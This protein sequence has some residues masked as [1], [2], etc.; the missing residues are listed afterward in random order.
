VTFT[1][2]FCVIKDRISRNLIGVGKVK[3]EVFLHKKTPD[4]QLQAHVVST[5]DLWHGHLGHP[6]RQILSLL[7][8]NLDVGDICIN[9]MIE[10]CDI[11]FLLKQTRCSFSKTDSKASE[12]FELTHYDIW[13][14]YYVPSTC[15]AHYFLSIVDD[16]SRVAWVYL[17]HD[18]N[19]TGSFLQR[20]VIYAKNYC[21]KNVKFIHS[22]NGNESTFNAKRQ[23]DS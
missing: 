1:N 2:I 5:Y 14:F 15:G 21:G 9:K 8:R 4:T 16:A 7:A 12:L 17:M 22:N 11:C 13:G 10:P 20:F 23:F 6:F 18:K 19:E 3:R